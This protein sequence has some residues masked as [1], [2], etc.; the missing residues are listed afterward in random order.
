MARIRVEVVVL[1]YSWHGTDRW[2]ERRIATLVLLCA[3]SSWR[4]MA[5]IVLRE[6][7]RR[8]QVDKLHIS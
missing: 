3:R 7:P 6:L 1:G 5:C 8:G 2:M 4:L